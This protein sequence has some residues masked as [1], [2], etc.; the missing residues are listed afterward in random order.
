MLES[1]RNGTAMR[2]VLD[3]LPINQSLIQ[4]HTKKY[5]KTIGV[6]PQIKTNNTISQL[7]HATSFVSMLFLCQF[8]PPVDK[9]SVTTKTSFC[10]CLQGI[11]KLQADNHI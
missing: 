8:L 5:R 2:S 4:I 11:Q 6:W 1:K 9:G 3:S 7:I 10:L